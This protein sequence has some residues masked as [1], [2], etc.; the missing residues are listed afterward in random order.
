MRRECGECIQGCLNS[1]VVGDV[2]VEGS[3]IY[4][5]QDSVGWEWCGYLEDCVEEVC[6]IFNVRGDEGYKWF[7]VV[8]DVFGEVVSGA[9]T[10]R[11]DGA[12]R[13]VGFVEFG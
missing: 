10:A 6:G 3:D 8:V 5:D 4:C 7:E 9:I 1:F 11:D 13:N 2:G 12:A